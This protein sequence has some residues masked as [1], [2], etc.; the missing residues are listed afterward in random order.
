MQGRKH[1]QVLL[2]FTILLITSLYGCSGKS[3]G[4]LQS[5]QLLPEAS[6]PKKIRSAPTTVQEA[7]RFAAANP[8]ILKQIP[9]YCGCVSEG[10]TNNYECYVSGVSED[11][12]PV[13][14]LH[15]LG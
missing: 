5:N 13:F 9:C 14:E 10:H 2:M 3:D 1:Y 7:Y 8:D 12:K 4:E 11:G 6:L 15:A